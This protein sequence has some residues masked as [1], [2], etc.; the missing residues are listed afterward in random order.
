MRHLPFNHTWEPFCI[1]DHEGFTTR[2]TMLCRCGK[3]KSK[4]IQRGI[5]FS[6]D[7]VEEY[8][9]AVYGGWA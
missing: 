4:S 2:L 5:Q 3:T 7:E 8:V 6:K 1:I 9:A